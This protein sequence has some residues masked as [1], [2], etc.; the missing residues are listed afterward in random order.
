MESPPHSLRS[1]FSL[2][3]LALSLRD[4]YKPQEPCPKLQVR[5]NRSSHAIYDYLC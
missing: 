5:D 4:N 3:S 1:L 2:S